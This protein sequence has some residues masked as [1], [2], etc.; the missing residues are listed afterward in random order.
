MTT[1]TAINAAMGQAAP[2]QAKGSDAAN[3]GILASIAA[4][5]PPT[6]AQTST[7]HQAVTT[8]ATAPAGLDQAVPAAYAQQ[9]AAMQAAPA[10]QA[11]SINGQEAAGAGGFLGAIHAGTAN[12]LGQVA[13]SMPMVDALAKAQIAQANNQYALGQQQNQYSQNNLNYQNRNLDYQNAM[14]DQ[15]QGSPIL[16]GNAGQKQAAQQAVIQKSQA[17]PV[18]TQEEKGAVSSI[19][20]DYTNGYSLASALNA[21]SKST[22]DVGPTKGKPYAHQQQLADYI[23]QY[24]GSAPSAAGA[25]PATAGQVTPTSAPH[26]GTGLMGTIGNNIVNGTENTA[27]LTGKVL[28]GV[29]GA[30]PGVALARRLL[31]F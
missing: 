10:A 14:L 3:A 15:S 4:A 8:A 30:T 23:T 1:S 17:D 2:A 29:A 18:L 11:A 19:L 24:F 28:G 16:Y 25:A 7:A 31:G 27:A 13:A 9:Q 6:P 12:Y 22:S 20:G 21:L 26:S 5:Q